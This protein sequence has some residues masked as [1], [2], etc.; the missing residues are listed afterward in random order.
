[1]R[2][3]LEA[4]SEQKQRLQRVLFPKGVT[5][6]D[7]TFQTAETSLIFRLL[8][9]LPAQKVNKVSPT[10]F[11]PAQATQNRARKHRRKQGKTGG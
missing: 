11:E 5:Y 4:S 10:G 6:A 8:Q 3:W 9:V 1:M 7:G 2:L